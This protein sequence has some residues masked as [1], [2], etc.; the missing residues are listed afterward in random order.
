MA[1]HGAWLWPWRLPLAGAMPRQGLQATAS[2]VRPGRRQTAKPVAL[3]LARLEPFQQ[4]P[5][6]LR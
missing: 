5:K 4:K 1:R 2:A 6:D 3:I